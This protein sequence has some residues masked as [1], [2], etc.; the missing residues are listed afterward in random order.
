MTLGDLYL[1]IKK[2]VYYAAAWSSYQIVKLLFWFDEWRW[3]LLNDWWT[4]TVVQA[5]ITLVIIAFCVKYLF[6]AVLVAVA[7]YFHRKK[8]D[9]ACSSFITVYS[10]K[11]S[12]FLFFLLTLAVIFIL[13]ERMVKEAKKTTQMFIFR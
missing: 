11:L 6:D 12:R 8:P 1:Q 4:L 3:S 10:K 7:H 13:S 2:I 5:A 9:P